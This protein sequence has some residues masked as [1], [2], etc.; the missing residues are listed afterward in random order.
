MSS[1]TTGVDGLGLIAYTGAGYQLKVAHCGNVACTSSTTAAIDN[2]QLSMWP[3]VTIGADGLGLISYYYSSPDD[4]GT[5][6]VAHC[7]DVACSGAA[8]TTL[9]SSAGDVGWYPSVTIGADG[10]PLISYFDATNGD[11]RAAHCAN[12]L[13]VRYFRRR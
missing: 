12:P 8:A 9:A 5:L 10:L 3:S 1:A 6:R 7:Y 4:H 11:L 2:T 13:C